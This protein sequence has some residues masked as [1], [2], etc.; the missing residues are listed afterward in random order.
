[1][2]YTTNFWKSEGVEDNLGVVAD[3]NT[4]KPA[5]PVGARFVSMEKITVTSVEV[6]FE[7]RQ[8]QV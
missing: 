1:M 5:V 6:Y 2:C 7:G 8:R 4:F 3:R